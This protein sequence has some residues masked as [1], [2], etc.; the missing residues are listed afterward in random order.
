MGTRVSEGMTAHLIVRDLEQNQLSSAKWVKELQGHS[1]DH[2]AEE[3]VQM[4]K[5]NQLDYSWP[6]TF[7]T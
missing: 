5:D 3:T 4:V 6:Q 1:G 2:R 7:S